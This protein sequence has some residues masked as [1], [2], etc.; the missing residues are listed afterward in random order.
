MNF[1]YTDMSSTNLKFADMTGGYGDI[2]TDWSDSYW[3][4]TTWFGGYTYDE[5]PVTQN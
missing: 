4:Q 5:Y 3:H 1:S 2:N